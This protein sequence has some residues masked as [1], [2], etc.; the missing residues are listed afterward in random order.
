MPRVSSK[1]H[2]S[3]LSDDQTP[4]DDA[5]YG[6]LWEAETPPLHHAETH[7]VNSTALLRQYSL[8]SNSNLLNDKVCWVH[9]HVTYLLTCHILLQDKKLHEHLTLTP[10]RIPP[11]HH[12]P[13]QPVS[14]SH[15]NSHETVIE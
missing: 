13:R 8:T 7:I 5:I 12:I 4:L 14:I 6:R 11:R 1:N 10:P 15:L 9:L 2:L 3:K